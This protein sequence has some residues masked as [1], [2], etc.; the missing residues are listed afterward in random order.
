LHFSAPEQLHF[1][2]NRRPVDDKI[3][4][5]ALLQVTRRQL[6]AGMYPF[7][8]LFVDIDPKLLD[9]N[10]HPRKSEVKFLDP[11][12]MFTLVTKTI[13]AQLGDQKVS[14]AAFTK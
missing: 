6:P 7:A 11:G 13:E 12:G 4:K 1:F 2:V 9:V 3:I 5:K 14:Y 8:Y 10:V